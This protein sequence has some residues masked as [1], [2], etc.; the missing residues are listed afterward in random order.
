MNMKKFI[1]SSLFLASAVLGV[2][3]SQRFIMFEEFTQASCGPCAQQ[4]PAFDALL[5]A[6]A[7]K[8]TSI[9]YMLQDI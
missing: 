8:C 3:Q 1:L 6:N 5:Q 2:S 7:S 9:K 4:N